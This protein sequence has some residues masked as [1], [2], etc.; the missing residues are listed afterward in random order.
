VAGGFAKPLYL[1]HAGDGSGRLFVVEQPGQV[2]IIKDGQVNAD[3]FLDIIAIVGSDGNEQGLLGLAFHPAY[4]SNGRFFVYY[5]NKEGD[6]VI[7]RYQV[8]DNPDVADPNSAQI[9]LTIAEPYS[10]HN[11]GQLAFGPDGYLYTGLGDGGAANDH[12]NNG[13]NL[14]TLLGKILRLDV[15]EGDPYGVPENNPFVTSEGSRPEI[16]SYGWRNPWRFSFDRTTGDMYIADVG[17]NQYEEVSFE[18]AGAA[19]QNYGWRLMEGWHCFDSAECDPA[20]LG[21]ILPVAEYDHGQGCSAR[22]DLLAR[23]RRARGRPRDLRSHARP[24]GE[25]PE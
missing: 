13:Q 15:D 9:L 4:P 23:G 22:D 20:S 2:L 10:N 3:P 17:Q 7:T 21:L 5:T 11:G 24:H 1:S 12:H 19:G 8:S 6:V 25:L 16:W 18:P 14:E